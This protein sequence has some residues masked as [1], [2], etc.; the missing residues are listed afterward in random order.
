MSIDGNDIHLLPLGNDCSSEDSSNNSDDDSIEVV[1]NVDEEEN[2]MIDMTKYLTFASSSEDEIEIDG[3]DHRCSS[4]NVID[5]NHHS[6]LDIVVNHCSTSNISINNNNDSLSVDNN[7]NNHHLLD[8]IDNNRHSASDVARSKSNPDTSDDDDDLF[9]YH[10]LDISHTSLSRDS[11]FSTEAVASS[12]NAN[13][14]TIKRKRRQWSVSEKL[15]AIAVFKINQNK[16][17]TARDKGCTT[18][19]LRKWLKNEEELFKISKE[20]KVRFINISALS[21]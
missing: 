15:D 21:L 4:V 10:P 19:Q 18:A 14:Q 17:E 7:N 12:N 1:S 6:T 8:V 20:K 9:V 5:N 13:K 16:R 3:D 11:R 2:T